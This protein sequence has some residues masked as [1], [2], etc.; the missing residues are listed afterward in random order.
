MKRKI[1]FLVL[2]CMMLFTGSV[3]AQ[4]PVA[5]EDYE[6]IEVYYT[7]EWITIDGIADEEIWSSPYVTEQKLTK[8]LA[9]WEQEPAENV[10]GYEVSYKAVYDDNYLY[11]FIKVKDDTYVPFDIEKMTGETNID[12]IELFFFPDPNDKNLVYE[13]QDARSRGLSQLRISVGNTQ[14]RATGGGYAMGFAFDNIIVGYEYTTVRTDEGYNIEVVVPWEVVVADAYIENLQDDMKILFDINAANCTDYA[15]NRVIILGWSGDDYHAWR[16]NPKYGDMVFKGLLPS[17]IS[18]PKASNINYTFNNNVLQ[19]IDVKSNTKVS[20]Y[21]L[22][23]RTLKSAIFN[24]QG[25]DLSNL[26]SGVYLVQIAE[27][28]VLKIIK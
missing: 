11:L 27:T 13:N 18:T 14:N 9:E 10:W 1:T 26:T 4:D 3:F 6:T 28:G 7:D 22:S 23:G 21:D 17:S 19:L 12:N 15:S 2:A 16:W 24:G 20:V 5:Y 25:I 8:T